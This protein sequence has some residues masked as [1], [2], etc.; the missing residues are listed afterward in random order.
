MFVWRSVN[1]WGKK[2][3]EGKSN[4]EEQEWGHNFKIVKI[5]S[6]KTKKR[7]KENIL[8]KR[9]YKME[10]KGEGGAVMKKL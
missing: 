7:K 9:R 4:R 8:R 3:E 10:E 6:Q 5:T 1:E 2:G